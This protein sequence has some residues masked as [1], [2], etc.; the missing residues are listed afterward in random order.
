M[1]GHDLDEGVGER[2]WVILFRLE[3][4]EEVYLG[5]GQGSTEELNRSS[6]A[7]SA[8]NSRTNSLVTNGWNSMRN[9]R[10]NSLVSNGWNSLRNGRADSTVNSAWSSG[11]NSFVHSGRSGR[12]AN[13]LSLI[14][15]SRTFPAVLTVQMI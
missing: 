9:G 7:N 14:A 15:A 13:S 12:M 1:K 8:R 6:S 4:G 5:M 10:A 3:K 2:L 11:A